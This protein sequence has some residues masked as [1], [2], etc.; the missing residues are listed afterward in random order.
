MQFA[1]NLMGNPVVLYSLRLKFL[2]AI[3][4]TFFASFFFVEGKSVFLKLHVLSHT[5]THTVIEAQTALILLII[6]VFVIYFIAT[7]KKS[8]RKDIKF[9]EYID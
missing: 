2:V 1:L 6:V 7:W 4:S 5:D 9:V 3:L 8:L